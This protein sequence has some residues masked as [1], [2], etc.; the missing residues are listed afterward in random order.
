MAKMKIKTITFISL[1]FF[2]V[3]TV[4]SNEKTITFSSGFRTNSLMDIYFKKLFNHAF[5]KLDYKFKLLHMPNERALLEANKGKVDGDVARVGDLNLE[6]YANLIKCPIVIG[7]SNLKVYS[8]NSKWKFQ[9]WAD[10]KLDRPSLVYAK[11]TKKVEMELKKGNFENKIILVAKVQQAFDMIIN[12]RVDVVLVFENQ[13]IAIL[14]RPKFN[15]IYD[16]GTIVK[17]Q[18]FTYIHKKNE[19]LIKP[20][21][22]ILLKMKKDKLLKKFMKEA[23]LEINSRN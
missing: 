17:A 2:S 8:L 12:K 7:E 15:E 21:T 6:K 19:F 20:L 18:G 4:S 11:G 16:N 3:T 9:K 5:E 13:T 22:I 10:L 23:L 1:L 14:K